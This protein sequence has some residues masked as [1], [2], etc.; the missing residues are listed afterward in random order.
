MSR[1]I[2]S[3]NSSLT[4]TANFNEFRVG[5]LMTPLL[6]NDKRIRFY[7]ANYLINEKIWT[8]RRMFENKSKIYKKKHFFNS[9]LIE[10]WLNTSNTFNII[11][12]SIDKIKKW[13]FNM[14][15]SKYFSANVKGPDDRH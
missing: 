13:I 9:N 6:N 3:K 5:I 12:N 10:N 7:P 4:T 14:S 1:N 15:A 2:W 8:F 11:Q